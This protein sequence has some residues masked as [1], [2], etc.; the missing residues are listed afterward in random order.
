MKKMNA[1][2]VLVLVFSAILLSSCEE[3]AATND[4]P[5]VVD[6]V[7]E[8]E[9]GNPGN[10]VPSGGTNANEGSPIGE[11][12][13]CVTVGETG[14]CLDPGFNEPDPVQ[15]P[16]LTC[17]DEI[18]QLFGLWMCESDPIFPLEIVDRCDEGIVQLYQ[19]R[20]FVF[21]D[22]EIPVADELPLII[23]SSTL[24][25]GFFGIE[26]TE[27]GNLRTFVFMPSEGDTIDKPWGDE[28]Y[29]R[30][31]APNPETEAE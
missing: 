16:P 9:A 2:L 18:A 1:I 22:W 15:E 27:D 23:E 6:N 4:D 21:Y 5:V 3:K 30:L 26:I 24:P 10:E 19:D 13:G 8:D 14:N 11:I 17:T 7:G 31:E 20:C 25:G 12:E 29:H 28:I